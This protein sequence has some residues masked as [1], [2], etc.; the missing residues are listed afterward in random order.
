MQDCNFIDNT[1]MELVYDSNLDM[2]WLSWMINLYVILT[3]FVSTNS[4]KACK[5]FAPWSAE[6]ASTTCHNWP[7]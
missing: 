7:S 4:H 5:Y 1:F 2:H 3:W 6:R